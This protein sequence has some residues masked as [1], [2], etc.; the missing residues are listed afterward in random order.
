MI[1]VTVELLSAV[2]GRRET[3]GVMDI[4]NDGSGTERNG[5][6]IGRLYR[7]GT[8]NIHRIGKVE[9]FPR[10]SYVVWRLVLRMLADIFKDQEKAK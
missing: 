6:Y 2:D 1:R 8:N 3:L 5:N 10:H 9:N 4:C 7:K